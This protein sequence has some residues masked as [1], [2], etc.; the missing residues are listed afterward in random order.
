MLLTLI[1]VGFLGV[2]FVVRRGGGGI[3]FGMQG[4]KHVISDN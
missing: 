3:K 2:Q 4:H 1:W